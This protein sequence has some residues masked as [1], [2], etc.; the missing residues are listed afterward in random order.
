VRSCLSLA[1]TGLL[2]LGSCSVK[3]DTGGT[4]LACDAAHAC[5][6]EFV[7]V[8]AGYCARPDWQCGKVNVLADDFEDGGPGWQ[9]S[10]SFADNGA[11]VREEGGHA[12][13]APAGDAALPSVAYYESSEWYS[14]NDSRVYI[15][16]P[17]SLNG[18]IGA[19]AFLTLVFDGD[20][21]ISIE[22]EKDQLYFKRH[23]A[24]VDTTLGSVHYDPGA[25]RWWQL[26]S[27]GDHTLWETSPDAF[28]WTTRFDESQ[29]RPSSL[30]R[31]RFG[32][33][34]DANVPDPGVAHFDNLNGG[35][36][37]GHACRAQDL[38][39]D[40]EG[41]GTDGWRRSSEEPGATHEIL[42]G[43]AVVTLSDTDASSAGFASS[44][45]YSLVDNG[46]SIHVLDVPTA[47]AG[48]STWLRAVDRTGDYLGIRLE[49][50]TLY[51]EQ[52]LGGAVAVMGTVLLD[53]EEHRFWGIA[54]RNG[55]VRWSTSADRQDWVTEATAAQ[56]FPLETLTIE[57]GATAT[58]APT[59]S[60][61]A[62]FD[63][64]R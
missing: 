49:Q 48:V 59:G 54:D 40:F 9:W 51:F 12:L 24:G 17:Q 37:L 55:E 61:V 60:T 3:I 19:R 18:G 31:T 29:L 20:D 56:A 5:P 4:N 34:A 43:T 25:H 62:R 16:V 53:P 2:V 45:A 22:Q 39:E 13:T 44:S 32:A 33:A 7:C 38:D 6:P 11:L 58:V 26:R 41:S 50:D 63:D 36:A 28:D 35:V 1:V 15:E 23:T 47:T 10:A 27:S 57:F 64:V 42:N 8:A 30:A 52:S 14:W 21:T 46:I